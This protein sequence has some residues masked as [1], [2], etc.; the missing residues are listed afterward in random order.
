MSSQRNIAVIF[1]GGSGRRMNAGAKPKQFLELQGKPIIIYTLELFERHPDVDA[2]YVACI[3]DWMDYLE[4]LV[5]KYGF[6]KVRAIIPGG[7]TGQDSI[8]EGL[9]AAN[10]DK[11]ND[12]DTIVMIHDGVRPLINAQTISDNISTARQKGTCITCVPA[13]ETFVVRQSNGDLT[14]PSRADSLVARAPQTFRLGEILA[15]HE[16]A[17]LEGH[18]D[19]IDSLTLMTHYG[20]KVATIIGPM[21]NIKITTPTDFYIFRAIV[22]ARNASQNTEL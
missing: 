6:Q 17:R 1:A 5:K 11:E 20:T 7:A 3:K 9:C 21:E 10:R 14:I 18:H 19:F 15:N 16:K 8:Y 2:I 12:A 22:E 13:I 4:R